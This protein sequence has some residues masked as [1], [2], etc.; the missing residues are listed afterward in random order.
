MLLEHAPAEVAVVDDVEIRSSPQLV[1]DPDRQAVGT[2][3]S[4]KILDR[5]DL[6]STL[7]RV[8]GRWWRRPQGVGGWDDERLPEAVRST[9]WIG[10]LPQP[11]SFR[12]LAVP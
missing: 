3:S 10:A 5:V 9:D 12:D 6:L 2:R 11:W 1:L 4:R 7:G 8:E